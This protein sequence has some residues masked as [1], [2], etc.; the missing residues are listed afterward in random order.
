MDME[1]TCVEKKRNIRLTNSPLTW[2]WKGRLE[3]HDME[4]WI[5]PNCYLN[6]D[7]SMTWLFWDFLFVT[8][9]RNVSSEWN[10][11]LVICNSRHR[12]PMD[13]SNYILPDPRDIPY[14]FLLPFFA[15]LQNLSCVTHDGSFSYMFSIVLHTSSFFLISAGPCL[16]GAPRLRVSVWLSF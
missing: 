8:G 12:I 5:L 1:R 9:P 4:I 15:S 16:P 11:N 10:G 14:L 2:E 7:E 13:Y 6:L 3:E